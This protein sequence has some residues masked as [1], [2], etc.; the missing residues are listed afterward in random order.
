MYLTPIFCML[1][2]R[3]SKLCVG[4]NSKFCVRRVGNV[5]L[6]TVG[7]ARPRRARPRRA[8]VVPANVCSGGWHCPAGTDSAGHPGLCLALEC[9]TRSDVVIRTCPPALSCCSMLI[10]KLLLPTTPRNAGVGCETCEC[11]C[12]CLRICRCTGACACLY[13][14]TLSCLLIGCLL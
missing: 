8:E 2:F 10:R 9:R 4:L 7:C 5:R 12:A 11:G 14:G 6:V 1:N 13:A 3:N